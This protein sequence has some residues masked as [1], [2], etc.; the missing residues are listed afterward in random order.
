MNLVHLCAQTCLIERSTKSAGF[1]VAGKKA[2][3]FPGPPYADKKCEDRTRAE[4]R[5]RV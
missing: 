5:E 2:D 4:K 3:T 1:E